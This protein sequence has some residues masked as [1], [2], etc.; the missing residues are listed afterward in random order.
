[1]EADGTNV[2]RL[3]TGGE[4]TRPAWSPDGN[5]IAYS[6]STT[7]TMKLIRIDSSKQRLWSR[8]TQLAVPTRWARAGRQAGR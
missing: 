8:P 7:G 5:W 4:E 3:T 2:T 6:D 1:M